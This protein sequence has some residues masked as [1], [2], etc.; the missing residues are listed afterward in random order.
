[1]LSTTISTNALIALK[2]RASKPLAERRTIG[3]RR[4]LNDLVRDDEGHL[5]PGKIGLLIGQWLSI[6]LILEHGSE[7]IANWDSLTVLF[8]VLIAPDVAK[9]LIMMKYG[10]GHVAK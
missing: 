5:S 6:K 1:M 9:K 10:N 4:D 3:L 2:N 8:M 7:I